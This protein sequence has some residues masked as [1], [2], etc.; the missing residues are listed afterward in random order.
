MSAANSHFERISGR[1]TSA[2]TRR[3]LTPS[4]STPTSP[5][6]TGPPGARYDAVVRSL[7]HSLCFGL[8]DDDEQVGLA[9][10]V[11]DF[12][13]F[14]YLC[15][16]YILDEH[17]GQGLGKWLIASALAHPELQT[18]RRWT[19]STR[20]AHEFYAVHGFTSLRNPASQMELMRTPP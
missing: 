6:P 14:A 16:V 10:V 11:T 9:R 4:P 17:R 7:Q 15:D 2:R 12:T 1:Y 5:K 19:L 18:V 8:Y 20:D 13:V 3:A